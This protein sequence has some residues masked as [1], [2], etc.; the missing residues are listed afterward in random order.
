MVGS[1]WFRNSLHGPAVVTFPWRAI[2]QYK[3]FW[4]AQYLCPRCACLPNRVL[5]GLYRLDATLREREVRKRDPNQPHRLSRVRC[6]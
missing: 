1:R 4:E 3:A 6:N 2:P 5:R